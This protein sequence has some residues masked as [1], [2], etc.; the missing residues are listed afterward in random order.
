LKCLKDCRAGSGDH[1]RLAVLPSAERP[2][3][4]PPQPNAI[5]LRGLPPPLPLERI[6]AE[7]AAIGDTPLV[8]VLSWEPWPLYS[9][10]RQERVTYYSRRIDEGVELVI[11]PNR[12]TGDPPCPT[13]TQ[14]PR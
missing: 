3:S 13:A 2:V 5:D 7:V 1:G 4:S 11:I 14:P 8:F 10:L 12:S 6:L 9:M